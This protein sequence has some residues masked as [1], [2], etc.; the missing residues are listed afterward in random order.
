MRL[1]VQGIVINHCHYGCHVPCDVDG[2]TRSELLETAVGQ[3]H[4]GLQELV[5][6]NVSETWTVPHSSHQLSS[7][8]TSLHSV[9]ARSNRSVLCWCAV[10]KISSVSYS[11]TQLGHWH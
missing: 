8:Y 4:L 11:V 2:E 9:L 5:T 1:F 7:N 10:L 6:V 3:C